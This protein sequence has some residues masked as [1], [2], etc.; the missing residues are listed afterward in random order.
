MKNQKYIIFTDL[1]GTLLDHHTYQYSDA[2]PALV[3]I[4]SHNIPLILTSSKTKIEMQGYQ[5]LMR[6]DE[7]PFIVENGSAIYT[8]KEYFLSV[9]AEKIGK[10]DCYKLG[11][12]YSEIVEFLESTSEKFEYKIL[13]FHNTDKNEIVNKTQL[14]PK[15]VDLAMKRDYSVPLFYDEKAREI[16]VKEINKYNLQIL[17]GGRFMH[18]LGNT[19]KG[20]ALN[21]VKQRYID[22]YKLENFKTIAIGDTLNDVAMLKEADIKILVKRHNDKYDQR[23][24]IENLN[25]SPY[26]GPKGW[27]YSL[28]EIL[29]LGE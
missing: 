14:S 17:F 11:K 15:A 18:I 12:T 16:L 29:R 9:D 27:N 19:N 22:K 26:I 23:V 13:G 25:Y 3:I 24:Q 8:G 28:L 1:D 10:Y 5:E 4:K 6:I 7:F 21:L 2:L 20:K